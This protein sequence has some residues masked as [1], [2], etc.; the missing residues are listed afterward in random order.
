MNNYQKARTDIH[1]AFSNGP[2]NK[3]GKPMEVIFEVRECN[4]SIGEFHR[5]EIYAANAAEALLRTHRHGFIRAP[6][7][8]RIEKDIEGDDVA[9]IVASQFLPTN[10]G[11]CRWSASATI[12]I[13][14]RNQAILGVQPKSQPTNERGK[15]D[16]H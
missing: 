15:Q 4:G 13:D 6:R 14:A 8:V 7:D 12:A 9:A 16:D 2:V 3:D 1:E 5:C 11:S 10:E